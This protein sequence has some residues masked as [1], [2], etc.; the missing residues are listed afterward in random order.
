[1]R[2]REKGRAPR[3]AG[4]R[5]SAKNRS[6]NNFLIKNDFRRRPETKRQSG[7]PKA[8]PCRSGGE[9]GVQPLLR[10]QLRRVDTHLR[11]CELV[12]ER[13]TR[14]V[15]DGDRQGKILIGIRLQIGDVDR[16]EK[17]R[18][19]FP[20]GAAHRGRQRVCPARQQHSPVQGSAAHGD[21]DRVGLQLGQPGAVDAQENVHL[22]R[23]RVN[24]VILVGLL[25]R[26]VVGHSI[27][28]VAGLRHIDHRTAPGPFAVGFLA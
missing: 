3:G 11:R 26:P 7:P 24:A 6:A 23:L 10:E 16:E 12:V 4:A 20:V 28:G 21:A 17:S 14:R 18:I 19:A 15:G 13:I 1:M 25:R 22:P 9:A 8:T 27:R 2:P 5:K